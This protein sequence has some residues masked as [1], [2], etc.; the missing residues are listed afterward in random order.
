MQLFRNSIRKL[1]MPKTKRNS[2]PIHTLPSKDEEIE[3]P[4]KKSK[5]PRQHWLLKSEPESRMENGIDMKFSITD[6]QN[7]SN[8]T[9]HWDG[10]RNY[11][12]RN[13]LRE[14]KLGDLAFFYHSN[15]KEPGIVGIV[16]IT[17]EAYPD[18]TSWEIGHPHYDPKSTP[19]NPRWSMV[20]VQF[21]S[22]LPRPILLSELKEKSS[23]NSVLSSMM[24]LTRSRLS[25][26]KVS[27]EE[28]NL[29]L[30]LAGVEYK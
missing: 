8:Q 22:L 19:E 15:C 5:I 20:D 13:F 4:L 7:C 30:D 1:Y 14:M 12:A 23:T 25:V 26:Q 27:E 29:I 16:K 6:L 3:T 9:S 2:S 24:L 17:K 21:Q 11:Q 18:S 10:V 28:W